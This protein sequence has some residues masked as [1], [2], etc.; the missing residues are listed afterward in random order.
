MDRNAMYGLGVG[1]VA[2]VIAL[3]A[4]IVAMVSSGG[5]MQPADMSGVEAS[6]AAQNAEIDLLEGRIEGLQGQLA[7]QPDLSASV[8]ELQQQLD[9]IAGME[10]SMDTSRIDHLDEELHHLSD[11]LHDVGDALAD[12]EQR[13][14]GM[15]K[16]AMAMDT[17]A[18][19]ER[20]DEI[21]DELSALSGTIAALQEQ[22]VAGAGI[23]ADDFAA[24]TAEIA[25]IRMALE[26]LQASTLDEEVA[27]AVARLDWLEAATAPAYTKA[28]VEEAIRRY[29]SEGRQETLDYYNTMDSVDGELY[30]FVIDAN[31]KLF[32]VHPT[33]PAYI[34]EDIRG[35]IGTDITGKNFGF[36]VSTADENGKWVDYVYLNPANDF[37][38]ERKLSW[39]IRHEHLIFGSGWYQRDISSDS[40]AAASYTRSI[41]EQAIV[42]YDSDG[43][44]ETVDYYNTPES[45]DGQWYVFI[46]DDS[47]VL[48][49][50][51]NP[52]LVGVHLNDV[53]SPSDGYP[54]GAQVAAAAVEGGAWTSYTYVNP[55]TGNV[56]T[57]HSWVIRHDG[58]VFGSGWYEEGPSRSD[59]EAYT[60]ALVERAMN[61]YDD[62][63]IEGTLDY[64][65]SSE[66][67]DGQWYVVIIDE[68]DFII[69]HYDDDVRGAYGLGPLGTDV[70]GYEFG[71]DFTTA[72]EDGKWVS[73]VYNNPATG[74]LG[75]KHSWVVRHDGL[76]FASGWYTDPAEY[77]KIFVQRALDLYE[78]EGLDAAIEYYNSEDSVEGQ[79]YVG[80][81]D[82]DGTILGH[83]D[84]DVRGES[85]LGDLGTDITGYNYGA[86]MVNVTED[87]KWISYVY[88]NP[89]T[90][91][92]GSKHSWVVLRDGLLFG[93][94][95]Y[96]EPADYTQH[97]VNQAIAMHNAEGKDA[98]VAYYNTPE[99]I[100]GQF[101][102]FAVNA[103][104]LSSIVNPNLP[105]YVGRTP[106]RIDPTGYYYGDDLGSAT[107]E[108][109]WISYVIRNPQTG[110]SQRKHTW[111]ALN[112]GIIW[113]SGWYEAIDSLKDEPALYVR[114]LVDDAIEFYESDGLDAT[115]AYYNSEESV[116][117]QYYVFIGDENDVMVAHATIPANVGKRYDEI[118]SADGYP[119]GAQVAAAAT[120]DGAWTSY[121]YPNPATGSVETKHSWVIRHD[122]R[123][124]GS[125]WYEEG[126]S[127]S[128]PAAYVQS[129]VQRAVNLYDDVG[130][131]VTLDYY[132]TPESADGPWYVFG[133]EDREG[134]LYSVANSNR[135]DIVG[136][137]R[138][139]IDSNG[140]NYG[141]AIAAVTEAGGGEWINYLFTHPQTREDAPKHS[142]VV[143]RDNLLFGAGWYEGIEE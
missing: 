105:D 140:F 137:T 117:G 114:S 132:N 5:E 113:G 11:E 107:E 65:N 4:I 79:W 136:T 15:D 108:G 96:S 50:H 34:G 93:S 38:H 1:I 87:G 76:L 31:S 131:D 142:W 128:D 32:V 58:R 138:E 133:L 90:G 40:V 119:A 61:L 57:K 56:E 94:G 97:L 122:G 92:L 8:T 22:L 49:A 72:D 48:I 127:K 74:E 77:T 126:P 71:K 135:P 59:S 53:I 111:L 130:R 60:Q 27:A 121:I 83:Y 120:E 84:D 13:L 141:E 91:E 17:D 109:K 67:V 9:A 45:M 118:V 55:A 104:D 47:D 36:E 41:V 18:I 42:R 123:I 112:D 2:I 7:A 14:D 12:L 33:V 85:L 35:E 3:I 106:A 82:E 80:I 25:S 28:Y 63:G 115:V 134:V 68:D 10:M 30:L 116:D 69:G 64:Y 88:N 51:A 29:D 95:W 19:D 89:S 62:L 54:A 75:S 103:D 129:L 125:G 37:A 26:E 23:V 39:V 143:R 81:I 43:L 102:V 99:R 44:H 70:T 86:E 66:S 21:G 6:L 52:D 124:F 46:T 98:A 100:D 73:Y 78:A 20:I 101:Y 139:R 24:V 16:P 110:V